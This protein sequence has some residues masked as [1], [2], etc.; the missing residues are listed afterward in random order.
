[1]KISVVQMPD[2]TVDYDLVVS[3]LEL[4]KEI[5]VDQK[6]WPLYSYERLEFEQYDTFGAIYIIAHE[7]RS[8]IGG[9]RLVRTDHRIGTGVVEYSYMIRDAY[10]GLLP[11]MPPDLCFKVPP[12]DSST[13]E[14]TRL[15]SL[16]STNVAGLILDRAN[17]FLASKNAATCLFLG[18]PAFLRMAKTMNYEPR[19]LGPIVR[20]NDGAFLAFSCKV[21]PGMEQLR[22]RKILER[23]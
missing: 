12:S 8:A 20:N 5:F 13:W 3:F 1:M 6:D 9:A 16:P 10:M 7:G 21:V 23:T 14:L 2:G 11:G 15:A 19:R 17:E 22:G 18:P 4:R